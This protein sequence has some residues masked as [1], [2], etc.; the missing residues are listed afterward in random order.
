MQAKKMITKQIV[1]LHESA[2]RRGFQQGAFYML[3]KSSWETKN[4]ASEYKLLTHWR[5][6]IK[7]VNNSPY[8]YHTQGKIGYLAKMNCERPLKNILEDCGC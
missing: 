4:Q 6:K 2:Y 1:D 8:N 7:R 5:F 3:D